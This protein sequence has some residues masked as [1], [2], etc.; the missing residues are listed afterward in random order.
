MATFPISPKRWHRNS[1]NDISIFSIFMPCK[2]AHHEWTPP[3]WPLPHKPDYLLII[4]SA[5]CNC[6]IAN[7]W[8][9][10][11]TTT[12]TNYYYYYITTTTTATTTTTTTTTITTTTTTTTTI[13]RFLQATRQL[14][15]SRY[16]QQPKV[17]TK[18]S[19]AKYPSIDLPH[20][21][22]LEYIAKDKFWKKQP[23][24]CLPM[25]ISS[26][27]WPLCN[28]ICE[29]TFSRGHKKFMIFNMVHYLSTSAVF[30]PGFTDS[31]S[32]VSFRSSRSDYK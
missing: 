2:C 20:G 28:I 15:Q 8:T 21:N 12:T 30:P 17:C 14:H 18:T 13:K 19:R 6:L 29:A 9:N 31:I 7:K 1:S 22:K 10:T 32:P 4:Y 26:S 23:S 11:T 24:E 25:Q 5:L 16:F 3:N 27:I